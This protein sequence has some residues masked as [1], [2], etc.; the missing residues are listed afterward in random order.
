M[1]FL[2][3][4]IYLFLFHL[5]PFLSIFSPPLS[6]QTF[7]KTI[8]FKERVI[9]LENVNVHSRK[10]LQ[11]RFRVRDIDFYRYSKGWGEE[12]GFE[13]GEEGTGKSFAL[14]FFESQEEAHAC[15]LSQPSSCGWYS[16][17]K[18]LP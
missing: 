2:C 10:N 13:E 9:R 14:L 1:I 17:L 12:A 16:D 4:K 18:L 6:Q 8:K 7:I 11:D 3:I 15:L 5:P